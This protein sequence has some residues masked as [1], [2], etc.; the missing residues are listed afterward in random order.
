MS[1]KAASLIDLEISKLRPKNV[2]QERE[3]LYDDVMKQRMT[4]NNL[5]DEN[6]KLKTRVHMIEAE[7]QRKD[8]VIDD[9]IVQQEINF[10]MP[11]KF[12]G[13][14][15]GPIKGETHLVINLKRRIKEL[16]NEKQASDDEVAALKRNI[17][18]TRLTEIEVEVKLYMDECARLRHQLEEVI[19]SKDTFADPQELKIIEEKF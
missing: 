6:T 9:L 4:T 11:N 5:K 2:Q 18:S 14:R 12:A 10:G 1:A 16:Q 7:L 17:R 3:R 13:G 15:G 19:K 8:K